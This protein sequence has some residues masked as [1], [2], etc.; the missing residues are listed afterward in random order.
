[1]ILKKEAVHWRFYPIRKSA[2]QF[3]FEYIEVFYNRCGVQK[4]LG[5][6]SP[7]Q[8][9]NVCQQRALSFSA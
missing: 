6:L 7:I 3:I 5:Y 2:R 4:R 8:F 9:L 1:M